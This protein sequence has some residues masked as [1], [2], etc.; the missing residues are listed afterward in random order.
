MITDPANP[1]AIILDGNGDETGNIVLWSLEATR[2]AYELDGYALEI[3]GTDE[4]LCDFRRL[5]NRV[6]Q[7]Q[8]GQEMR[9]FQSDPGC[10]QFSVAGLD[11][12]D[13]EVNATEAGA[14]EAAH[15]V[16]DRFGPIP[17][18]D[19]PLWLALFGQSAERQA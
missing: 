11:I 5:P 1:L 13:G 12:S 7:S 16:D 3:N 6:W 19:Y 2:I 17:W 15:A 4:P 10:W 8:A 14:L 18:A 9:V